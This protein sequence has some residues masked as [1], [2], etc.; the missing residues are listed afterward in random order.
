MLRA[1]VL[2]AVALLMMASPGKAETAR[3]VFVLSIGSGVYVE[4][5]NSDTFKSF[6]DNDAAYLGAR[7]V[8][9]TFRDGGARHVLQLL[10]RDDR[11][12]SAE[13]IYQAIEEITTKIRDSGAAEPMLIVYFSGHGFSDS[14]GYQLFLAPGDLVVPR[15]ALD[16]EKTITTVLDTVRVGEKAPTALTL[17]EKLDASDIPYL[18][19]L[20]TC[21]E[22]DANLDLEALRKISVEAANLASDVS[23]I[24]RFL[25]LPRGPHPVV[26]SAP[27][28]TLALPQRDPSDENSFIAPMARRLVLASQ[29]AKTRRNTLNL[30][31]I[32]RAL[33][34]KDERFGESPGVTWFDGSFVSGSV[35]APGVNALGSIE[36]RRG[37]ADSAQPCC[38]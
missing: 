8:A 30:D 12:V 21:F 4:A 38:Q 17:K 37:T 32:V 22:T 29:M 11:Y 6:G 10:G 18:L 7:R 35:L 14:F 33:T 24:V 20:D 16:N 5:E 34:R 13:N 31:E 19:I 23:D 3:D 26:F 25:N 2:T 1:A 28:G 36:R 27:P 15:A 9:R